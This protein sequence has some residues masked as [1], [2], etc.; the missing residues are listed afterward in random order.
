LPSDVELE[1]LSQV[2][3][4]PVAGRLVPVVLPKHKEERP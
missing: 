3:P 2:V 4:L 1:R